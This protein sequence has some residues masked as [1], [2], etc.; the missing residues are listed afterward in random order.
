MSGPFE[1][2]VITESIVLWSNQVSGKIFS[3]WLSVSPCTFTYRHIIK[4][5]DMLVTSRMN[6]TGHESALD[7]WRLVTYYVSAEWPSDDQDVVIISWWWNGLY[8]SSLTLHVHKKT[9]VLMMVGWLVGWLARSCFTDLWILITLLL[10]YNEFRI[11]YRSGQCL[12][13]ITVKAV[14]AGLFDCG[15]GPVTDSR[16]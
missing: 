10:S 16:T 1:D 14:L 11:T 8:A 13:V 3:T 7:T 2:K 12:F 9:D 4:R 15:H 5:H 6:V